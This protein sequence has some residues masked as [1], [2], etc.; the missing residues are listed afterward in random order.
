MITDVLKWFLIFFLGLFL[1][2]VFSGGPQRAEKKNL[3]PIITGPGGVSSQPD[4]PSV[5]DS[6][7]SQN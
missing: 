2:W 5:R 7:F 1:V 3:T 4:T 6:D